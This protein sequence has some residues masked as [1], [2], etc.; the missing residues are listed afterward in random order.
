MRGRSGRSRVADDWTFE[1]NG[2]AGV[3]LI[4]VD[5]QPTGWYLRS[6][7]L[8]GRDVTD[9]PLD[10][11]RGDRL[12]GLRVVLSQQVSGVSGT[13]SDGPGQAVREF[14]AVVFAE[15]PARWRAPSRFVAAGR[16]N[17]DGRFEIRGLPAGRYL[18]VAV[19]YLETGE[20]QDVQFLQQMQGVATSILLGEGSVPT[21][22]LKLVT[23]GY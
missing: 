17:Q 13:V 11:T 4:R 10:F 9:T 20:E 15:D 19:D 6:V 8:S 2:L 12:D 22:S 14:A 18:A 5:G 3:R 1:L 23:R 7:L 21:V 16:P